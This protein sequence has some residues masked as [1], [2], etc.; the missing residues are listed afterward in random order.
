MNGKIKVGLDIFL[1]IYLIICIIF[2]GLWIYIKFFAPKTNTEMITYLSTLQDVNGNEKTIVQANLYENKNGDGISLFEVKLSGYSD[3]DGTDIISFGIQVVGDFSELK[4]TWVEYVAESGFLG[5]PTRKNKYYTFLSTWYGESYGETNEKNGL[6][7][8]YEETDGLNYVNVNSAFNDFGFIRVKID[9]KAYKLCLGIAT[10][11][12]KNEW[13]ADI[14][15]VSSFSMFINDI[16]QQISSLPFGSH[17]KTFGYKNMFCVME[18]KDGKYENITN[19]DEI[20]NYFQIEFNHYKEGATTARDSIFQSIQ[21]NPSFAINGAS[22]LDEYFFN[23][24][25]CVLTEQNCIFRYNFDTNKYD[26]D[27]NDE[28]YNYYKDKKQNYILIFDQTVLKDKNLSGKLGKI[29][30]NSLLS[31]LGITTYK[32]KSTGGVL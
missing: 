27:L 23:K 30:E 19:Q 15:Q 21:Y 6:L 14:Y 10:D 3:K 13:F 25:Y 26:I 5:I 24:T 9:D 32:Y 4:T 28:S 22:L 11:T 17:K 31:E 12:N 8:F 18:E 29:Q 2:S 20:F 16:Y 7:Y 1:T